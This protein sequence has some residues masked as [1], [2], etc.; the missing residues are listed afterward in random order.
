MARQGKRFG[1]SGALQFVRELGVLAALN[2]KRDSTAERAWAGVAPRLGKLPG[3]GP[4]TLARAREAFLQ[5][6]GAATSML[7]G[8]A[9]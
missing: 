2:A 5:E 1:R 9:A 3:V 6:Y 8:R 4:W 7:Y